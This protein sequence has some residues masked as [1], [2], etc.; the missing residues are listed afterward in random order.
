MIILPL[1][2]NTTYFE[3]REKAKH[4]CCLGEDLEIPHI[5]RLERV[6]QIKL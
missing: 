3:R 5:E 2:K 1:S 4:Y 6:I